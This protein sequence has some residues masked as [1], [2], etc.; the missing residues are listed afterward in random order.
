MSERR[1]RWWTKLIGVLVA[2]VLLAGAGELALR[3]IVPG[4]IEGQIRSQLGL[5]SDHP[6]DVDMGGSALWYAIGGGVGD[7]TVEVPG[8][9]IMEGIEVDA[10]VHAD[11]VPFDPTSGKMSNATAELKV[12]KDQLGA[13]VSLLT[14]GIAQTGSVSG[15]DLVVGR[16]LEVFGQTVALSASIHLSVSDGAVNVEP[17]G[18]KAAGFDMDAAQISDATGSLLDPI[19]EPQTVCV[20]DRLPVGVTLTDITL[21]STG[22]ASISADLSPAIL[23]DAAQQALGTCE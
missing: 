8:A 14:Q 21:S 20:Q 23:S 22:S 3:L 10:V 17:R 2:V 13:V 4:I 5:S 11:R 1:G 19:L 15:D 7:V 9:P 6:V 12:G 16:E 18:V